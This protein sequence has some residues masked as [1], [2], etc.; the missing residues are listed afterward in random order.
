MPTAQINPLPKQTTSPSVEVPWTGVLYGHMMPGLPLTVSR[1]AAQ[2]RCPHP[3]VAAPQPRL[4]GD[5]A[6]PSTRSTRE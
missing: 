6:D 1:L 2:Q 3:P 4:P 5:P